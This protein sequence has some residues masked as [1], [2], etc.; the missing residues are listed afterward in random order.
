MINQIFHEELR[1]TNRS[2]QPET[3][4][5]PQALNPLEQRVHDAIVNL[6]EHKKLDPVTSGEQHQAFLSRFNWVDSQVTI[7]ERAQVE[8]LLVKYHN[9][10][11]R[12]RLDIGINTEF[13]VEVTPKHDYPVYA[14]R[15]LTPTYLEVKI[16]IE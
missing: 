13:S 4:Y 12:H 6:L 1:T 10:F 8:H 2:G 15:L 16:L 7:D 14:Q 3:C 5:D 9:I 11:E